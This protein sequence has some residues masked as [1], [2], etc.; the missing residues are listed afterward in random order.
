MSRFVSTIKTAKNCA[1][2]GIDYV[3]HGVKAS[4]GSLRVNFV[5][6][7]EFMTNFGA[8]LFLLAN[9]TKYQRF[10][11]L[12]KEFSFDVDVSRLPCG[13]NGVVSFNLMDMDG[14]QGK[15]PNPEQSGAGYGTGYCD[16]KCP[17]DLHFLN[18]EANVEGWQP[19][20]TNM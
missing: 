1:F 15:Y 19:S 5:T 13:L 20:S 7:S 14:Q 18:G 6:S 12:D 11:L 16:A 8:R 3:A 10:D 4:G 9:S 2:D 17:R